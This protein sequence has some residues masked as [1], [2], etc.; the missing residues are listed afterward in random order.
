[1]VLS[2]L[3]TFHSSHLG[4]AMRHGLPT[5]SSGTNHTRNLGH[6]RVVL[7]KAEKYKKYE[8]RKDILGTKLHLDTTE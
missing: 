8:G 1:M 3:K 4:G 6:G 7:V 2:I 5:S